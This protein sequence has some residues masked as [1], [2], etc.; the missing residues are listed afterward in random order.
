MILAAKGSGSYVI[1]TTRTE[2]LNEYRYQAR[3]DELEVEG[4]WKKVSAVPFDRYDKLEE[5]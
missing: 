4:K 1:F 5:T 2:Y 3:M